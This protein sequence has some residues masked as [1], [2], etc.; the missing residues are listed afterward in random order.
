MT[1]ARD[2]LESLGIN[3]EEAIETDRRLMKK[4]PRDNRI[5]VCGHAVA[6]HKT[7]EFSGITECKPSRMYCPCDS[8]R[9]VLEAEDTRMFLRQTNGPKSEHALVR[10]MVALVV[11]EKEA[12][13]LDDPLL[14]DKCQKRGN[15]SPVA[16]T[17]NN[18][19]AYEP[20]SKNAL[21]CDSCIEEL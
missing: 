9:A 14:C 12:K 19:I 18:K 2:A 8:P 5:C 6:R 11:A 4:G 17:K 20:S 15:I 7:D 16:L 1:S 13:W 21:L 3:V 10:G